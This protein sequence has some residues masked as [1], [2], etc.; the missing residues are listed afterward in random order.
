MPQIRKIV[1]ADYE[2]KLSWFRLRRYEIEHIEN[3]S[4]YDWALQ[5]AY[6]MDL[7]DRAKQWHAEEWKQIHL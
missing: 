6:R 2:R 3:F 5:I 1:K 4:H 7:I